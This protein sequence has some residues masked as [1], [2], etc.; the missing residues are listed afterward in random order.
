MDLG[1]L[2]RF[3]AFPTSRDRFE[4]GLR[5]RAAL[6]PGLGATELDLQVLND[7]P[8]SFAAAVMTTGERIYCSDHEAD[9]AFRRDSQLRAADLAPFLRRT[10]ALKRE[11][12]RR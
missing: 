5:L 9:H 8:P 2:L 10:A 12:I 11:A 6:Q 1:I 7:L 3:D 4:A